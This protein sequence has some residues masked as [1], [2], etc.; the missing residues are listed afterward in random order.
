MGFN[1]NDVWMIGC[2]N[3]SFA[4]KHPRSRKPMRSSLV[5]FGQQLKKTSPTSSNL[6]LSYMGEN[7]INFY[8]GAPP[9]NRLSFQRHSSS[10]LSQHLQNPL[11]K[12]LPFH[13]LQ[14]LITQSTQSIT[15]LSW[16]DVRPILG[17]GPFYKDDSAGTIKHLQGAQI[18]PSGRKAPKLIFLGTD[19]KNQSEHS[20]TLMTKEMDPTLNKENPPI[21]ALDV[22]GL[23]QELGEDGP[24]LMDRIFLKQGERKWVDSRAAAV[25]FAPWEAGVFA[26]AR[27]MVDWN[28]RNK[29]C[30]GCGN[31]VYSTWGGWKLS[32]STALEA[33]PENSS[34]CP[35]LKSLTNHCYPRT[36]CA[37]IMAIISLDGDKILLGRQKAWPKG[38]YSCLAGF[39]EPGESFEEA[40]RREVY[41]E[42]GVVVNEVMYHSSQPWPYPANLMVGCFGW[43]DENQTIRLDLDNELED[44]RWFSRQELLT[45]LA[46]PNGT[47][48]NRTEQSYFD[49]E[50]KHQLPTASSSIPFRLPPATAIA[51]VLTSAW[52]K[53]KV[54]GFGKEVDGG[55]SK[56]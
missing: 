13:G 32:C 37:V 28:S 1:D 17:D 10:L 4:L 25:H 38:M 42:S 11:T 53:K 12:F 47:V 29:F 45:I 41:E 27:S 30:A 19:E 23:E 51:G 5:S 39:L 2:S 26:L 40:V 52:A 22:T 49:A 21:F 44:A 48:I 6:H 3:S 33:T 36:D 31:E 14:P 18:L 34:A 7:H 15:F 24:S 9:L 50:K 20:K 43:A 8:A 35:S 16:Q 46:D 55:A 54:I 56:I